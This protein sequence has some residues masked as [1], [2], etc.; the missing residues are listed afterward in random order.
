[1]STL[2]KGANKRRIVPIP[3]NPSPGN[4]ANTVDFKRLLAAIRSDNQAAIAEL[5]EFLSEGMRF[6]IARQLAPEYVQETLNR[7][8]EALIEAIKK[9]DLHEP[10]AV[11]AYTRTLVQTHTRLTINRVISRTARPGEIHDASIQMIHPRPTPEDL[12]LRAEKLRLVRQVLRELPEP[13]RQ[14]LVRFYLGERSQEQICEEMGLTES[15]FSALKSRTKA[16]L[17]ELGKKKRNL[18]DFLSF[19][20][21]RRSVFSELKRSDCSTRLHS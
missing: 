14:Q 15:Q 8:F 1:M 4:P 18:T 7:A 20:R 5:Y 11:P 2:E 9:G 17:R 10:S 19:S 3:L 13:N 21:V 6:L 16:R 12:A